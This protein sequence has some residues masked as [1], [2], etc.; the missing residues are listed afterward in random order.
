MRRTLAGVIRS[1][2]PVS[3][4]CA[5]F[6]IPLAAQSAPKPAAQPAASSDLYRVFGG[7][8]ISRRFFGVISVGI[9]CVRAR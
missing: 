9:V 2:L 1:R 8:P 3:L 5:V 6:A 4:A 7:S